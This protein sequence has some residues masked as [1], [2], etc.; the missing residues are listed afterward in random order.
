MFYNVKLRHLLETEQ[1][2]ITANF[3]QPDEVLE[4]KATLPGRG[5]KFAIV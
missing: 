4:I 5:I 1:I 2:S 3:F